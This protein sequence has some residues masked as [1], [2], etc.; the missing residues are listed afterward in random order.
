LNQKT[1]HDYFAKPFIECIDDLIEFWV[2]TPSNAFY[3]NSLYQNPSSISMEH[4]PR[5]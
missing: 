4:S 1:V 2:C 3:S 5:I